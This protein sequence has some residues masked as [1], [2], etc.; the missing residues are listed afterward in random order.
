MARQQFADEG[1]RH[2][3]PFV[4]IKGHAPDIGLVQQ[5]GGRL[6][7]GHPGVDQLREAA[8]LGGKQ[9][10]VEK[11]FEPV[12]GQREAFENEEGGLVQRIRCAVAEHQSMRP[13]QADRA[14]QEVPRRDE[15]G[16]H[17]RRFGKKIGHERL[18]RRVCRAV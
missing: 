8:A 3:D 9:A 13:K 12:D 4:N 1:A 10:G 11:G 7:C 18:R 6:A 5:V 16:G 2:D 17:G 14:A 15:F